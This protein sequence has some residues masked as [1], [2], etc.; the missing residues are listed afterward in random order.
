MRN[1]EG[2]SGIERAERWV[3]LLGKLDTPT[4]GVEDYCS[5][6]GRALSVYGVELRQARVSWAEEGWLRALIRLWREAGD[7]RESWVLLQYTAMAWSRRGFP[8]G[9]L[10]AM[11]LLRWRGVRCVVVFHEHCG[12]RGARV[13]DRIREACQNWVIHRLY[14]TANKAVFLDPLEKIRWLPLG[15]SKASFIPIGANMPEP[16]RAATRNG[17]LAKVSVFCL[18]DPPIVREELEDISKAVKKAVDSGAAFRL[19]FLGRGTADANTETHQV[20]G[21]LGIDAKF[22]GLL[23][24]ETVAEVLATCEVMLCVRGQLYMRRGSAI[25]GLAAGLAIV[26]YEGAAEGTPLSESGVV[27]VPYRNGAALG[28]ALARVLKDREGLGELQ[29]R[30]RKAYAMHFAWPSIAGRFVNF[31]AASQS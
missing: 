20:F 30:S 11:A 27:L 9:A 10:A 28:A 15:A 19:V 22:L 17:E 16:A 2:K 5:Y 6:L 12:S 14:E 8:F 21:D 1:V 13:S 7:W 23:P 25:A 3:A 18:S 24:A 29:E 31:L 4:D 26:G